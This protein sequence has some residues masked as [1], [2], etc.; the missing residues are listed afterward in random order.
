[1]I[2]RRGQVVASRPLR[3]VGIARIERVDDCFVFGNGVADSKGAR[4]RHR[5]E[6]AYAVAKIASSALKS[7]VSGRPKYGVMKAMISNRSEI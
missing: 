3:G 2:A 6:P 5:A 4:R 1:M 7:R